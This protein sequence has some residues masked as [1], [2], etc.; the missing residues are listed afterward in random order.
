MLASTPHHVLFLPPC[1][2][3]SLISP[4]YCFS[5]F[6]FIWT[7]IIIINDIFRRNHQHQSGHWKTWLFEKNEKAM[8]WAE[9]VKNL[10]AEDWLICCFCVGFIVMIGFNPLR[11]PADCRHKMLASPPPWPQSKMQVSL[12]RP[13][14]NWCWAH[15][16]RSQFGGKPAVTAVTYVEI[17]PA[18]LPLNIK[19]WRAR[20]GCCQKSRR[21]R[22]DCGQK[23]RQARQT[24][25]IADWSNCAA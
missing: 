22:R 11:N 21:A 6:T 18:K 2:H 10:I 5:L 15:R 24:G 20:H 17:L 12:S 23:C 16:D 8:I 7:L 9:N 3:C 1:S 19:G 14:S 25:G 13:Q 4:H